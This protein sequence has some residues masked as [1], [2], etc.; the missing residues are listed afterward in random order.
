MNEKLLRFETPVGGDFA[1]VDYRWYEG[2]I[3]LM[4]TFVPLAGR[5][6]GIAMKLAKHALDYAKEKKLQIM[7]YCPVVAQYIKTHRNMNF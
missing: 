2:D 7:V 6:K 3:A 1:Y 4:H 5:G